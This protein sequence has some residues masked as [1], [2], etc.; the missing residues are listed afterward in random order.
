MLVFGDHR[1][2]AD[3]RKRL[4]R[5]AE[6]LARVAAMPVGI[7]RHAKLVGALIEAGQLQQGVEDQVG[8]CQELSEFVYRL[9][10]CVMRSSDSGFADTGALPPAPFPALPR[11]V[12]LKLPEGFAF[13]G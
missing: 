8:C 13:Y 9:A 12:E 10:H 2:I 5:L 11:R 3:P 6:D 4:R 7:D 1:E